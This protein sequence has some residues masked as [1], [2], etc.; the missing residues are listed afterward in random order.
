MGSQTAEVALADLA[1]GH[2]CT[3]FRN[4]WEGRR[5]AFPKHDLRLSVVNLRLIQGLE[6]CLKDARMI[7]VK[8]DLKMRV[9]FSQHE[10][11][12]SRPVRHVARGLG[13]R[14]GNNILELEGREAAMSL[15]LGGKLVLL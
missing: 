2:M 7:K 1:W 6:K 3:A 14:S 12:I 5:I 9:A 13:E 15:I 8:A 4:P 11:R 10:I